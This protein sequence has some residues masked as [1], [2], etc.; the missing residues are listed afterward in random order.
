M[1]LNHIRGELVSALSTLLRQGGPLKVPPPAVIASCIILGHTTRRDVEQLL[2]APWRPKH[3]TA[4]RVAH[5][6]FEPAGPAT[7]ATL[8]LEYDD[9]GRVR[10]LSASCMADAAAD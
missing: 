7:L 9:D 8:F 2:G 1:E 5:Y 4:N 10:A 6:V 3:D